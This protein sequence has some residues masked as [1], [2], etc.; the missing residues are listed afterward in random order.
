MAKELIS[1]EDGFNS[2]EA[3]SF[4][5]VFLDQ[6][7]ADAGTES[8]VSYGIEGKGY[9]YGFNGMERSNELKGEGNGYTALFWEYDPR[10]G[11]RWNSDPKL[12]VWESSYLVFSNNP[13]AFKDPLGD[14]SVFNTR[15]AEIS[16]RYINGSVVKDY[17]C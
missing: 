6:A 13:I 14:S 4:N 17:V 16:G 1:S 10:L 2:G 8:G 12:K 9:R 5:T 3:D 15:N 7:S 11:K